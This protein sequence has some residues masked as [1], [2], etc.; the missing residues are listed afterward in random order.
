MPREEA[1]GEWKRRGEAAS[2]GRSSGP[3]LRKLSLVARG[4]QASSG[5]F[6]GDLC[7]SDLL[8]APSAVLNAK[9]S[10]SLYEDGAMIV[11]ASG[12]SA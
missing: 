1:K 8:L 7:L 12:R 2:S 10:L 4:V 3:I 5:P 11:P 9:L 6:V